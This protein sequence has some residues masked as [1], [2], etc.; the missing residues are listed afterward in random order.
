MKIKYLADF[1]IVNDPISEN[2][3]VRNTKAI[4]ANA[5]RNNLQSSETFTSSQLLLYS[6]L[7]ENKI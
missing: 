3:Y 2:I 7:I 5:P 4:I 6:D 1:L